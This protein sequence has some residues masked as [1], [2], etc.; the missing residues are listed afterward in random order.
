VGPFA[1]VGEL[2]SKMSIE[3]GAMIEA[4][5]PDDASDADVERAINAALD[6]TALDA[7]PV[8]AAAISPRR[9]GPD[10]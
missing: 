4:V 3:F 2:I 8:A 5:V 7:A 10:A 1:T 9:L 6:A